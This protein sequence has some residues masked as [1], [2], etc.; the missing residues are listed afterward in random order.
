MIMSKRRLSLQDRRKLKRLKRKVREK[1]RLL[2][3]SIH[4]RIMEL[5]E[6]QKMIDKIDGEIIALGIEEFKK[7]AGEL[8][9]NE[10]LEEKRLKES[11]NAS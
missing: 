11:G 10:V 8:S 3:W 5:R 1:V 4:K 7:R 6:D 9:R 2:N